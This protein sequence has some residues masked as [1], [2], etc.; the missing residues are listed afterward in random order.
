M[1]VIVDGLM[2]NYVRVGKGRTLLLVHGWGDNI[3]TFQT[4][5]RQLSKKYDVVAVDLPG[6]GG[7]AAPEEDWDVPDYANFVAAFTAK[8][9]LDTYAIIGHSNGGAIA[10]NGISSGRLTSKK[11]ILLASAG[12]RNVQTFKKRLLWVLAK[13]AKVVTLSLPRQ[14]RRH[15][16]ANLYAKIGSDISVAEH[17]EGSFKKIVKYDV[18]DE[19]SKV[20]LPTLLIYGRDD[21][22]TPPA[23][24]QKL[25]SVLSESNLR[26]IPD[27]GH[28]LLLDAPERVLVLCEEFL[29]AP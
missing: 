26:I 2:T 24:G 18:V 13:I 4:F 15:L 12:V 5:M 17:L 11:L 1:N 14:T 7:T 25:T 16:R 9:E 19:A 8:L 27:A 3:K 10:I 28:F 6:F 23:Y 29:D 20:L 22:A 21:S